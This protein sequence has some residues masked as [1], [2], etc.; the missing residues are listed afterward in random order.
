MERDTILLLRECDAGVKM[1]LGSF[2][3]VEPSVTG[4]KMKQV[5]EKYRK[6]HEQLEEAIDKQL[7]QGGSEEKQPEAMASAFSWITAEVKLM[8]HEEDKQVAKLMMN[9]CN[10]AIQSVSGYLNKYP[11]A[12]Q[13]AAK[14]AKEIVKTEEEFMKELE[15][16]L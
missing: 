11:A 4:E 15:E 3:H 6:K 1:G 12:S 16:F 5:M 13:E 7:K 9:G 8:M 10:M 14:T 2:D